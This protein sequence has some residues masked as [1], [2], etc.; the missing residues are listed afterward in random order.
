MLGINAEAAKKQ[1]SNMQQ[2]SDIGGEGSN[3]GGGGPNQSASSGVDAE[4]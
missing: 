1:I 4:R 2:N 3:G